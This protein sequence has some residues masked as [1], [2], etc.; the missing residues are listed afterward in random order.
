MNDQK[1]STTEAAKLN[2]IFFNRRPLLKKLWQNIFLKPSLGRLSFNDD[3]NSNN[4]YYN[5]NNNND[6]ISYINT[7]QMK[8]YIK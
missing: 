1:V 7:D 4:L 2:R 8:S 3:N 5:W 6:N